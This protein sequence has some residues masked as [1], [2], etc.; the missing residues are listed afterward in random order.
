MEGRR[1]LVG[2]F[3]RRQ[4]IALA[5][6]VLVTA[7]L[8]SVV[9]VP[10]G[11]AG[12]VTSRLPGASF[13]VIGGGTGLAV[14]D[15]A[16]DLGTTDAPLLDLAGRTLALGAASGRPSWVFFWATWCPPCQQETPDIRAMWEEASGS[17][18]A[19]IGVDVQEPAEIV[20]E[21]AATYGL[22]YPI[23]LDTS[24]GTMK[25]FNVFGLPTHYFIDAT[26]IIRDRYFGP[27][28]RQQMR[29]RL[30][31]IGVV[32][33]GSASPAVGSHKPQSTAP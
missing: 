32:L 1:S 12:P 3:T 14:G 28:G 9:T 5:G 31:S 6:A 30:A 18:L 19:V 7:A 13:Y 29:D 10:L 23:G 26:G 2:P 22:S 20:R 11:S 16:P 25:R 21:Y 27:L 15:R 33:P 24:A 4:V 8:L 17:G